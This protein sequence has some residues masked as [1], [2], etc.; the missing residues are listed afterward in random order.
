MVPAASY[1]FG[2]HDPGAEQLFKNAS[3]TGWVV[4]SVQVNPADFNGDFTSPH[5]APE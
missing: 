2:M 5:S 4:V 1:I 3:R